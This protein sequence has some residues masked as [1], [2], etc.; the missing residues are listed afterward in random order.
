MH[1]E[2]ALDPALDCLGDWNEDDEA[3]AELASGDAMNDRMLML[4]L[5]LCRRFTKFSW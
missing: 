1:N 3:F 5:P 4:L 2:F